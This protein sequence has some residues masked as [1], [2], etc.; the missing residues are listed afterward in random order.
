MGQESGVPAERTVTLKLPA[1][2]YEK[3]QERVSESK[4]FA[5]MSDYL[6]FIINEILGKP[7]DKSSSDL[8]KED[9]ERIEERLRSLGYM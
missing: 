2:V 9:Q 4:E 6:L 3:L 1:D 8:G 7:S 5:S